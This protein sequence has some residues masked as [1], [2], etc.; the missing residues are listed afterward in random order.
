MVKIW[1]IFVLLCTD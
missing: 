1:Q